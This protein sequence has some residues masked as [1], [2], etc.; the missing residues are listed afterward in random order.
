MVTGEQAEQLINAMRQKAQELTSMIYLLSSIV[1]KD[2]KSD[3]DYV[4]G[5]SFLKQLLS[6]EAT[7]TMRSLVEHRQLLDAGTAL[8]FE[9]W[10]SG[11]I[12]TGDQCVPIPAMIRTPDENAKNTSSEQ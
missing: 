10:L 4:L 3:T 8:C 6:E 5:E 9:D 11:Y 2:E 1:V 7:S 12:R